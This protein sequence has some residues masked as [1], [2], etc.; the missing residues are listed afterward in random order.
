MQGHSLPV[1]PELS[2]LYED[3]SSCKTP[4]T[5]ELGVS[6]CALLCVCSVIGEIVPVYRQ[7]VQ[8]SLHSAVVKSSQYAYATTSIGGPV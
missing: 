3:F 4:P 5:E 8:G 2:C 7:D 6:K 1:C